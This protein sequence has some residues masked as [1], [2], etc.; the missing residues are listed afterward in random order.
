MV[1]PKAPPKEGDDLNQS[2]FHRALHAIG[3][4]G[5]DPAIA[6]RVTVESFDAVRAVAGFVVLYDAWASLTWEHKAEMAKFLGVGM[7]S[8]WVALVVAAVSFLELG[9]AA[10]FISG[11][12]VRVMGWAGVA[13]G[14]VVWL[15]MEHGGD[16][17]QDATDPGV[18]L[19]YAIMFLFVVGAERLRQEP[20]VSRNDILSLARVAFGLLWAYDAF[21]K[22]QPYFLNHYLD[23]LTAAQKDVGAGSWQ[24]L[25]D[26]LWIAVCADIG[27]KLVAKLVGVTEAVL[28]IGLIS[29]RGLRV[30]GPVG[31]ALGLV[32]WST[33]EEFG[34]PY[35]VG[36]STMMP[37]ALFGV[38]II[39][40]VSLGY[41]WVLYNPL[42]LFRSTPERHGSGMIA[43]HQK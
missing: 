23:Y 19:P 34:G 16:F 28:A 12:G 20:N 15:V 31:L 11:K 18:G 1:D 33:A 14:L 13:Y 37:M 21:L 8:A 29:G 6:S 32:I 42:D 41:V 36:A 3:F 35:S 7:E 22:F 4:R 9:I 10:S 24:G 30:L 38:A 5:E 17:G 40:V 25:W 39:Y 27:G 26:Q 2:V 43:E